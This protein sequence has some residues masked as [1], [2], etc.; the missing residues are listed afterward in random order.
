MSFD[1][2]EVVN[3]FPSPPDRYK[4]FT[5]KNIELL[6]LL[7][8]RTGTTVHDPLPEDTSQVEI[9]HDQPHDGITD[10]L[11][12]LEK[13][14]LDWIVE[15]GRFDMYADVWKIVD[16]QPIVPDKKASNYLVA[17]D[18][19]DKRDALRRML[20]TILHSYYELLGAISEHIPVDDHVPTLY[21]E[22]AMF[23]AEIAYSFMDVVNGFRSLQVV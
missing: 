22:E 5:D 13:P 11:L 12:I 3:P 18:I 19:A 21:E 9:L 4:L 6:R 8:E 2:A 20:K 10:D 1:I 15:G 23:M 17:Q 14:R 7:R 16:G